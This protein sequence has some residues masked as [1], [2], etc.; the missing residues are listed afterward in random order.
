MEFVMSDDEDLVSMA[1]AARVRVK[2]DLMGTSSAAIKKWW[3]AGRLKAAGFVNGKPV[4]R[5]IDVLTVQPMPIVRPR[6]AKPE[7]T[8][9]GGDGQPAI[10]GPDDPLL[11]EPEVHPDDTLPPG[12]G[13]AAPADDDNNTNDGET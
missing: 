6:K 12:G 11:H 5:R 7:A 4:F 10:G 2:A 1:E 3:Q 8:G 13:D 9:T